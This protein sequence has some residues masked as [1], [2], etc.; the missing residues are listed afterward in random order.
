MKYICTA[1][2]TTLMLVIT[3]LAADI[4]TVDDDG[5]DFPNRDF[6]NIQA[7]IDASSD[8]DEIIVYPGTYTV[9]G[10][11]TGDEVAVVN[12]LGLDIT[13]RAYGTP[14]QTIID[15]GYDPNVEGDGYKGIICNSEESQNTIIQGFKITNCGGATQANH[16]EGGGIKCHNESSPQ[17]IGCLITN[18]TA[19]YGAGISVR[20]DS[21][22]T[23]KQ[24]IIQNNDAIKRGGG[25]C[26]ESASS[27][28][29]EYCEITDNTTNDGGGGIF[30]HDEG[31]VPLLTYAVVCNNFPDQ[32]A[33]AGNVSGK[34]TN[35][36]DDQ[37]CSNCNY[38]GA[39]C[40]LDD[41]LVQTQLQC[42]D[43]GGVYLGDSTSCNDE[44]CGVWGVGAC[45]TNNIC[46]DSAEDACMTFGGKWLGNLVTCIDSDCPTLCA[47]D[48][49]G[50]GEVKVADLLLLIGAWGACP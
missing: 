1:I 50:D 41:C 44:L 26:I 2:V 29:F 13:L 24:C 22:P 45:C 19:W 48:L 46:V 11:V 21:N 25:V 38:F 49:D 47:A 33:G 17:I 32:I 40:F 18:N 20:Y 10:T 28:T 3:S 9:T 7:A 27:P 36:C 31:S 15:G 39:C 30:I 5:L 35:Y 6:D 34:S 8:G 43:D 23:I 14:E 16:Y 37:D 42:D 12:M 4:R